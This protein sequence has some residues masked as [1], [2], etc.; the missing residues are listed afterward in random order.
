MAW[1]RQDRGPLTAEQ[2]FAR[3]TIEHLRPLAALLV[4][5]PPKRKGELVA[6]LTRAMIDPARV[7]SLYDQL[8]PVAKLAVR[9]ATHDPQGRYSRTRFVA[10]HGREPDWSEPAPKREFGRSSQRRSAPT[11]VVL[12]FPGYEFL[13]TDVRAILLGLVPPP[14]PFRIRTDT[15]PPA[16]YTL[17]HRQWSE[18]PT[19]TVPVRVRETAREA[20][21]DLPAVLRL[22]DAGK[23]RVTDKRHVPTE[24]SRKAVA[25]VLTGGEF[26]TPD[27]EDEYDGDPA[28]DLAVKAFAWPMLVQA[29][30]LAEKRG[31]ALKLTPAGRDALTK[32]PAA[33]LKK[34]WAAWTKG[35]LLDEFSR[36]EVVK[37]Q[38]ETIEDVQRELG[39]E[40]Q[41]LQCHLYNLLLYE[42]GGFF[43]PHRD[44]EKL[45]R[46]VATLVVVLPSSFQGANSWSGT[47]GRNGSR[48]TRS[49]ACLRHWRAGSSGSPITSP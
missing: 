36:V 29:A 12:F 15:E 28:H 6:V 18:R 14:D 47:R 17:P 23:V 10:R 40:G 48:H 13:P 39:L 21:A 45:D 31:D 38:S 7:R 43:L 49:A 2:A 44:G 34:V 35:R 9:E 24:A 4:P 19:E 25:G 8:E 5:D 3:L 16:E 11:P 33:T 32:P 27:D 46:M 22:V 41:K 1:G 26:Y 37:G 20:E 30:G 42:P